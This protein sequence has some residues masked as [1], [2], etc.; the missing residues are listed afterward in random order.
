LGKGNLCISRI[1]FSFLNFLDRASF[2]VIIK[3]TIQK[4]LSIILVEGP[5][6]VGHSAGARFARCRELLLSSLFDLSLL[7]HKLL[8]SVDSPLEKKHSV[9][10]RV[11]QN[12]F[13]LLIVLTVLVIDQDE[14]K[15][16]SDSSVR[17]SVLKVCKKWL[18]IVAIKGHRA[19]LREKIPFWKP[20]WERRRLACS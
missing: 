15:L 16:R 6:V 7:G 4:L 10:V 19:R 1:S 11:L 3:E 9:E 5:E 2:Y 8:V 18:W 14:K 17:N 13:N 20:P 12:P